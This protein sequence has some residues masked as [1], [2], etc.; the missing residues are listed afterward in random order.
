[1]HFAGA[2][3][4]LFDSM[5][6]KFG[7]PLVQ[8]SLAYLTASRHG[9]SEVE[10]EHLMSLDDELL[11]HVYK[12]WRPPLRRVPP[13][14][15]TRVRSEVSMSVCVCLQVLKTPTQEGTTSTVDYGQVRGLSV[16][17]CVCVCVCL[18]VYKF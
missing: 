4:Q 6:K 10:L 2:I 1:M 18:S 16:C 7:R 14:L 8:H 12:F 3:N 17:V 15:W 5:E 11:N 9:L 13:L